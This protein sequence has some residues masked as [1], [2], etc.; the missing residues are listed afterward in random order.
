[1]NRIVI[2]EDELIA[3][4]YLKELLVANGFE[5]LEIIDTGKKAA[6]LIPTLN[7]DI[8][9]MDIMLKDNMSGSEVALRLKASVPHIA[10]LFL[11]AYAD[12]EMV[13]YAID[14][15]SYGYLMKPYNEKEIVN[16]L[17]VVLARVKQNEES[18]NEDLVYLCEELVFNLKEQKLLKNLEEVKLSKKALLVLDILCK[19]KNSVV[20]SEQLSMHVWGVKK[21]SVTIRTQ[22][23]R[24]RTQ[25]GNETIKN[26][27]G[28]GYMIR[29]GDEGFN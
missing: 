10:I 1:L 23:H 15:N 11:T 18:K 3:A 28:V 24:M 14:A 9:L 20:S 25:L 5:V 22:I 4:E 16:T 19:N 26:I 17:K 13:E 6:A 2:V 12:D 29:S 8:V 7:P 21:N 27:S